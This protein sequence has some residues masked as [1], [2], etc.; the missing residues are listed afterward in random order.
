MKKTL[1][2][3]TLGVLPLLA[4]ADGAGSHGMGDMHRQMETMHQGMEQMQHGEHTGADARMG[5][6]GGGHAQ[7]MAGKGM[8]AGKPGDP[9]RV[10]RTIEITMGDGMRF[11]PNRLQVRKGETIRFFL[12][13][14]GQTPHEMVIG[15][16]DEL[17]EHAKQM[18]NM[19]GMKHAEPNMMNVGAGKRGGLVWQFTQAGTVDFACLIPGHF[20]AGMHGKIQVE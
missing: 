17:R 5:Q 6:P 16:A 15:N 8:S 10:D 2:T 12:K 4:L 1:A 18:Q 20:E 14:A 3:L 7:E 19:P 13:N 11:E 9:G